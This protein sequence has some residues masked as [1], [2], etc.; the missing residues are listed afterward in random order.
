ML[1]ALLLGLV[2]GGE[3]G[4]QEKKTPAPELTF[5]VENGALIRHI[6]PGQRVTVRVWTRLYDPGHEFTCPEF[7]WSWG[8][9]TQSTW[10]VPSCSPDD[11]QD[12]HYPGW[13]HHVY[14]TAGKYEI[15]VVIRAG[16]KVLRRSVPFIV[17]D[18]T[19]GETS[20]LQH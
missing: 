20:G 10:G 12:L 18:G 3:A 2:L 13:R 6:S 8:D 15:K 7:A 1:L 5:R 14:D 11:V 16:S 4:P 9:E 17:S 19:E